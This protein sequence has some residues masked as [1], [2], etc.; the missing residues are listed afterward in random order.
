[1]NR[2]RPRPRS[3]LSQGKVDQPD[4]FENGLATDTSVGFWR[5]REGR[6]VN[7]RQTVATFAM[8]RVGTHC[9]S[10]RYPRGWSR[11]HRTT[12]SIARETCAPNG[13]QEMSALS[14]RLRLSYETPAGPNCSRAAARVG[15]FHN[16]GELSDAAPV[17]RTGLPRDFIPPAAMRK[18]RLHHRATAERRRAGGNRVMS[19]LGNAKDL[20]W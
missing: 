9:I 13:S 14:D 17:A 2:S 15:L 4:P 18:R 16:G 19:A 5:L 20:E 11:T 6:R 10:H 12:A 3:R 8:E 7:E 1:M